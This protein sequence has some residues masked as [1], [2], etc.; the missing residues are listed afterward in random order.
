LIRPRCRLNRQNRALAF[1]PD[2]CPLTSDSLL[3]STL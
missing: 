2:L 3:P 1:S